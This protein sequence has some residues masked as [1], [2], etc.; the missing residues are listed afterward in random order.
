MT[1]L[2]VCPSAQA[3]TLLRERSPSHVL[4]F[5]RP[6]ASG[7]AE[8]EPDGPIRSLLLRFHDIDAPRAGLVAPTAADV[9]AFLAFGASWDGVRPLLV[10][11]EMGI[12]RS[13][14]AALILACQRD[15]DRPEAAIARAL[16]AA[17]PC[18][19]PNPRMVA[20][21]DDLLGRRGRMVDAA[22][23]IGRGA[24]YVPYRAFELGQ[25]AGEPP[26]HEASWT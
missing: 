10:H 19:T 12:S 1:A 8:A 20:L 5:G 24:D 26:R 6:D 2:I 14:A 23:A 21:A 16:R 18:A 11:C 3:A 9:S 4:G 17:A 22:R 7:A 13:P 15:P 25:Q